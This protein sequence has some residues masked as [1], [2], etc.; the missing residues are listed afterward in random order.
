MYTAQSYIN[1]T[2]LKKG[3]TI[4]KVSPVNGKRIGTYLKG[5]ALEINSAIEAAEKAFSGW[6]TLEPEIRG[7][8]L[9]KAADILR[10]RS[11]E[12]A[13][14]ISTENG[15]PLC[16]SLTIEV[17]PVIDTLRYL[18]YNAQRL[19]KFEE[20]NYRM[21]LFAHKKAKHRF[22]PLGVIGIITP[23]NFPFIIPMLEITA[24]LTAGNTV[25]FKPAT[26]TN[27]IGSKISEIF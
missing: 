19:L 13:R 23:W 5:S 14:V 2:Y 21:P 3:R 24:A 10:D 12:F 8:Y 17:F 25:V 4:F 11:D 22:D 9:L 1:G 7:K 6:S 26:L 20:V 16:E 18:G 15:K 27:I